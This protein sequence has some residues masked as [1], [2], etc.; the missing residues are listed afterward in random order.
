MIV[1]GL[2]VLLAAGGLVA[3]RI[4]ASNG[5]AHSP[6]RSGLL[7]Y[8]HGPGSRLFFFAL[9]LAVAAPLGMAMMVARLE[10]G[11]R[12]LPFSRRLLNSSRRGQALCGNT[13]AS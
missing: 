9:V 4:A 11:F 13:T 7:G 2:L 12:R 3:G 5:G 1:L 6:A 10:H 8:P